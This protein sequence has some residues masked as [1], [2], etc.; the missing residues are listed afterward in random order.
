MKSEECYNAWK[1]KKSQVE[2]REHFTDQIMS[3]VNQYERARAKSKFNIQRLI[4]SI[5]SRPLAK[6]AM[7]AGGAA[8]G[9]VRTAFVVCAFLHS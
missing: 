3:Q 8:A 9:F 6:A 4:D 2:V 7:I 1:E 5:S